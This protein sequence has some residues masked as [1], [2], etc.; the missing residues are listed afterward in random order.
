M[1]QAMHGIQHDAFGPSNPVQWGSAVSPNLS[2]NALR[3]QNKTIRHSF[4]RFDSWEDSNR[5]PP[6]LGSSD[7]AQ[8]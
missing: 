4:R 1:K 8:L 5:P 7:A 6:T 3:Y 2:K